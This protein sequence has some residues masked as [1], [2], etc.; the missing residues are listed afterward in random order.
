[1]AG[2]ADLAI[3]I[4][5]EANF[6]ELLAVAVDVGYGSNLWVLLTRSLLHRSRMGER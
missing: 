4:E 2:N 3:P 5:A 1:M 6:V